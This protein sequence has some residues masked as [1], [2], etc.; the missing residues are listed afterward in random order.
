MADD[1]AYR[2]IIEGAEAAAADHAGGVD[3]RVTIGLSNDA[4]HI[5][6]FFHDALTGD[7]TYGFNLDLRFIPGFAKALM[8]HYENGVKLKADIDGGAK[9]AK[10]KPGKIV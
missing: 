9:I 4:S 7:E 10:P 2:S 1:E 6:I 3:T 5:R 8:Q